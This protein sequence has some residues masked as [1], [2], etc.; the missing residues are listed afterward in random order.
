MFKQYKA[1][2]SSLFSI[3]ASRGASRSHKK[4][5]VKQSL[6]HTVSCTYLEIDLFPFLKKKIMC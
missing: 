1:D 4:S 2:P 6:G 3:Y 5:E